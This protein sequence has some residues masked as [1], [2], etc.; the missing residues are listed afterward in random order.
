MIERE[1]SALLTQ[2]EDLLVQKQVL[3]EEMRHRV[4]NSLR[5]IASILLLM[6]RAVL[7]EE[8][9][10]HLKDDHQ[11]VMSVAAVQQYLHTTDGIDQIDVATYLTKLCAGLAAST[12][13]EASP[14]TI[15]ANAR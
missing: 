3:L 10:G 14:I 5:I 12:I 1:K 9:R 13:G 8:T 15:E 2:T 6:A 7:S 11:R 4:A